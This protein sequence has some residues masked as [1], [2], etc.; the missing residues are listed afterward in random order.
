[1]TIK[2]FFISVILIFSILISNNSNIF[3]SNYIYSSN[4]AA[5]AAPAPPSYELEKSIYAADLGVDSLNKLTSIFVKDDKIYIAEANKIIITDTNFKVIKIIS[6]FEIDGNKQTITNPAGLFVTD[7]YDIY[8]TEPDNS[9]ILVFDENYKF[10][11]EFTK[12]NAVGLENVVYKPMKLVVDRIGRMFVV[13]KNVYEGI[14]ELTPDGEFSRFYGVNEVKFNPL[15]L[16]WRSIATQAQRDRMKLWLPTDFS[17]IA[18]DKDGF[19][20]TTSQG[21][22]EAKA[23]KML[24]SK[25]KDILR[26]PGKMRPSG[27]LNYSIVNY[28]MATGPSELGAVDCNDF[29]MYVV[30][31][32]KR[33]RVFT[34]NED[35]YLLYIFGGQG[36]RKTA[37][38]NP[39]DIKFMG[40][41]FLV[42]DSMS[43]SIQVMKPTLYAQSIN[44]AT[45][46]QH[47]GDFIEAA[48]EWE[49][50]AE[51]NPNL[52]IAFIG[53]GKSELRLEDYG[54][55]EADF[56]TGKDRFYYSRA[57]ERT[58]SEFLDSN[59]SYIIIIIS[60]LVCLWLGLKIYKR[61]KYGKKTEGRD[62]L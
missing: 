28:G 49:K 56:K 59:F 1:M 5:P 52:E 24:N 36:D 4:E 10:S 6:E 62:N 23:L 34:Y 41:K 29:G 47:N 27:D 16:F 50:V 8:V 39:V 9:R 45:K 33:N 31:D 61:V 20:F 11:K 44:N 3:A 35:G 60:L 18:L 32:I 40:D 51:I 26:Y 48:K 58:R 21:P 54:K 53:M 14:M 43:Q 46:L 19:I 42:L 37:F 57:F 55:A 15:E 25:G 13:A 38:R 2:Q 7:L 17:N 12:P 22:E 30:L